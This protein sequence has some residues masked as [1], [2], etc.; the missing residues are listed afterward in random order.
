[1]T[2][3]LAALADLPGVDISR[4]LIAA[5]VMFEHIVFHS[6]VGFRHFAVIHYILLNLLSLPSDEAP[7][8]NPNQGDLSL[9]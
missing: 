1:M 9:S 6:G 4:K 2:I 3:F 5:L 8:Q 7:G